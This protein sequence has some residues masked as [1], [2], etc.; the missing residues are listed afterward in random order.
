MAYRDFKT[1]EEVATQFKIKLTERSFV[2]EKE[3]VIEEA[4]MTYVSSNLQSRMNYVS[5]NAICEALIAPI[6]NIVRREYKLGLWSHMRFDVSEEEGLVGIPDF[7]IAPVSDIGTTFT[8][9]IICVAEAKK[10]DFIAGWGQ[11]LAIM[12]ATQKY[13]QSDHDIYGIVT[14]GKIWEIG[15]LSKNDLTLETTSYSSTE[16]LQKLFNVLN[17]LFSE[18]SKVLSGPIEA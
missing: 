1:Y 13:N 10:D 7:L 2:R 15:K 17:W 18:S 3:I 16:N 6:L 4:L 11:A 8:K 5:E 9:P 14:T 12:I